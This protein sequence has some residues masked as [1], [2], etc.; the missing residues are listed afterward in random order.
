MTRVADAR[1]TPAS[2]LQISSG[3]GP[4]EAR[5]FVRLLADHIARLGSGIAPSFVGPVDAPL[6]ATIVVD[7]PPERWPPAN[8]EARRP[9]TAL[10]WVGTHVL[11]APLRG[12]GGRKRWFVEV[13][14]FSDAGLQQGA[15]SVD[16]RITTARAG[17]PGG[18]NV[19]KRATAVRVVDRV[20]GIAVRAS[21]QRSQAQNRVTALERLQERLDEREAA[22]M[23][24]AGAERRAAH[25]AVT[26]GAARFTW[27]LDSDGRLTGGE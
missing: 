14:P 4:I 10:S 1:P 25:D 12:R 16:V 20:S 23:A 8:A 22:A 11:L 2:H 26:R 3:H 6:S 7:T 5:R 21:G 15:A 19:N 9:H 18:Q 13:R 27:R 17:G 24:Q